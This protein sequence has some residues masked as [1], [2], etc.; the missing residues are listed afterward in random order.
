M[1]PTYLVLFIIL[2]IFIFIFAL[3]YIFSTLVEVHTFLKTKVPYVP[4]SRR[5]LKSILA[6]CAICPKDNFVDLGSGDGR[7][8]FLAAKI[9]ALASGFELDLW[10]HFL[11]K[12]KKVL[13]RSHTNFFR[14]DFLKENL[15]KFTVIY[16][17]LMPETVAV[18]EKKFIAE[19][20]PETMAIL[21]QFP[22]PNLLPTQIFQPRKTKIYVY[23]K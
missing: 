8:V 1:Q 14:K 20:N 23:K 11:A 17:Y 6:Q 3:A 19:C 5:E 4:T 7:A 13:M 10:N 12:T 16:A 15:G 2:S 21:R 18:L 22:F 9:G